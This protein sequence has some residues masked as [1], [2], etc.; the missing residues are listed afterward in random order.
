MV[1]VNS[2]ECY[3][4]RLVARGF[5]YKFCPDYSKTCCPIVRLESLR[6]LIA[7]TLQR[8]LELDLVDVTNCIP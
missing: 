1:M 3:K 7:M 6:T 5:N 8:G 4:T 2:G